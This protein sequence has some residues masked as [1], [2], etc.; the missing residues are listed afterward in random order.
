MPGA[1]EKEGREVLV[2]ILTRD[3]VST[4]WAIGF[5]ALA[6]PP[7]AGWTTI[8]GMPFDSGRNVCCERVLK[9]DFKYLMFLDDD[10]IPPPDAYMKLVK[11]NV[12]IVSGLYVRR[13]EPIAP[14]MIRYKD[15]KPEWVTN[16]VPDSIQEVDLVGAGCLLIHKKV[17]Q[18]MPPP[19]FEW[20]VDRKDL[21]P[22]E[23]TSED[24][25]FCKKAKELG[26]KILVDTSVKCL[27]VGLGQS[28]MEGFCPIAI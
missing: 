22:M 5:K 11:H 27:H 4:Q 14:V 23:R 26:F 18:A 3:L 19:W 25:T 16:F 20:K 13:T 12:D 7:T 24:F 21:P 10:V 17:L 9:N 8:T 28:S 15:G 6:L 2:G 1:W